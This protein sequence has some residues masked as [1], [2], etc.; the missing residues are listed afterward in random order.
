MS[1]DQVLARRAIV[2]ADRARSAHADLAGTPHAAPLGRLFLREH[3]RGHVAPEVL[4]T[5]ELLATELITDVVLHART[6]IHLGV[7]WDS[8][9]LLV[10]VRENDPAGTTGPPPDDLADTVA[11]DRGMKLITSLADDF[12]SVRVPGQVGKVMWFA[13]GLSP[14]S[15]RASSTNRRT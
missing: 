14:A 10:T 1:C 9:N 4:R 11:S 15:P 12:G 13:L 6:S 7:T 3:I 5:A 2:D 8:D